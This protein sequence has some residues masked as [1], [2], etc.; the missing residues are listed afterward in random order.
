MINKKTNTKETMKTKT[1]TIYNVMEFVGNTPDPAIEREGL[2]RT[3]LNQVS[4]RRLKQLEKMYFDLMDE[5]NKKLWEKDVTF[6][7]QQ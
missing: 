1:D 4:H 5:D 3:L 6:N 7:N 2:M